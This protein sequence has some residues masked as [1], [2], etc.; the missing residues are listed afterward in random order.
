MN[1][2]NGAVNM[3]FL[4]LD[5]DLWSQHWQMEGSFRGTSMRLG[6]GCS[7]KRHLQQRWKDTIQKTALGDSNNQPYA[8]L[9]T[10]GVYSKN[11][12][13]FPSAKQRRTSWMTPSRTGCDHFEFRTSGNTSWR[14]MTHQVQV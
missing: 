10:R 9:K 5:P 11:Q 13:Q 4:K 7:K 6:L 2:N 1:W 14:A 3:R 12:P 8:T